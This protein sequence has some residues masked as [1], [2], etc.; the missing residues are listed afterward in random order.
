[1]PRI[2]AALAFVF[3][4]ALGSRTEALPSTCLTLPLPTVPL[5]PNFSLQL[6]SGEGHASATIWRQPCQDGSGQVAVLLR[7]T[8]ETEGPHVCSFRALIVQGGIQLDGTFATSAGGSPPFP[9]FCEGLFVPTTVI[10]LSA[11]NQPRYDEQA[12]VTLIYTGPP[13]TSVDIPAAAVPP[14]L[15]APPT[16]TV[17][18]L[19]CTACHSGN[20]L[21][22]EVHITNPGGPR[23]VELKT[24]ARLPDGSAVTILG[25]YVEETIASGVT[26]I[27]LFA[28][29]VLPS[30]IP[31]GTYTIEA[32]LLEP[33]LGVT[34]GRHSL[35]LTVGP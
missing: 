35:G 31:T 8:P 21:G 23:L 12:A 17:H 22:F 25:R 29:L 2:L 4:V 32:A 15:P 30:G 5:S 16:L 9:T 34:I 1:M 26:V 27:P 33:E 6:F 7:L 19:G 3:V 14:P 11:P 20:T 10:L 18:A 24:G 13:T 28:G